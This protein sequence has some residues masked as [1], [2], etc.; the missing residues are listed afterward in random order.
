[1]LITGIWDTFTYKSM[2]SMIYDNRIKHLLLSRLQFAFLCLCVPIAFW[3]R[4]SYCEWDTHNQYLSSNSNFRVT[5]NKRKIH[6][7]FSSLLPLCKDSRKSH[8]LNFSTD[9]K[10]GRQILHY[11]FMKQAKIA[12]LYDRLWW[13]FANML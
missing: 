12:F 5:I 10:R 11:S 7:T 3:H 4:T 1:M 13:A 9:R 6:I 8:P 2:L